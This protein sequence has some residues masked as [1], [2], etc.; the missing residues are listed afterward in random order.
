MNIANSTDPLNHCE[1]TAEST[2]GN[3]G[4]CDGGGACRFW[5]NT[6]VC[7]SQTCT[8]STKYMTD[9]C[10]GFGLCVDAGTANCCP[11]MCIGNTCRDSCTDNTH[12]CPG[13]FCISG[14]CISKKPNG[15][16]C[17]TGSECQSGFCVDGYCCN[18]GCAG[19]CQACNVANKLGTCTMLA[20]NT[21]P[22]NE[23]GSCKVCNGAG[24]CVNV[25]NGQDPV[26]E[27][28]DQVPCGQDGYCNGSAACRLW[29]SGTEC[30][31]QTCSGSTLYKQD[32]CDGL[33]QCVDS[34]SVS[35]APYKCSGNACA[36]NCATDDDC[37][38]GYYC[39]ASVC[40][41]KKGLGEACASNP[42]CL[43]GYC[44]DGYC[45]DNACT[46]TCR[47]CNITG[48]IGVC[49]F[50]TNNQDLGSECGMCQACNGAGACKFVPAGQDPKNQCN[51]AAPATCGDDG[52]CSGAGACRKYPVSTECASQSCV[53][54]TLSPTDY[55]NGNGSCVDSPT[56]SCCPYLCGTGACGTSCNSNAN[57]C[58]D[59][60]CNGSACV[61]K[62]PN[63]DPC[64]NAGQCQSGFCVDGY[65]CNTACTGTCSACNVPTKLGTCSPEAAGTD[66]QNECL[67]CYQCNGASACAA[68]PAGQDPFGDCNQTDPATCGQ[69][70]NCGGS[71]ACEMWPATTVCAA[72]TC[73]GNMLSA[74]DYCN[75]SGTC[76]DKG[77]SSCCPYTCGG[78]SC[79][80]GCSDNTHCCTGYWCNGGLCVTKKANGQTCTAS[81]ECASGFC[82]DGVCCD[83]ACNGACQACNITG[84]VGN[85][86]FHAYL[87]DPDNDC[88]A[89][90][91]CNGAGACVNAAVGTDPFNDCAQDSQSTC[92][93]DGTCSGSGACRKWGSN[94]ICNSQNCDGVT[95]MFSPTDYCSGT[96]VCLDSGSSSCCPFNCLGDSCRT[97]CL[98]DGN[99]CPT[100]LCK[101]NTQC[102]NCSSA[103]PCDK[104]QYC[105]K[106][107]TCDSIIEVHDPLFDNPNNGDAT[108]YGSTFGGNNDYDYGCCSNENGSFANDRVYHFDTKADYIGVEFTVKVWGNFDPVIYL[109][110]D[111]CGGSGVKIAYN[112]DY[113]GLGDGSGISMKLQPG[114]D[115]YLYVDG[116][117]TSRGEYT[118][119]FDFTSLCGNCVCDSGYGET[120]ATNPVEC[121]QSGDYCGNFINI[122]VS[123]RPQRFEFYD[124]LAGDHDDV[125]HYSNNAGQ[126]MSYAWASCS[127]CSW[128]HDDFDKVYRLEI[129]WDSTYVD[130]YY[131]R[132]GGWSPYN[133]PRLIVWRASSCNF[134]SV[135][136]E[137][138]ICAWGDSVQWGSWTGPQYFPP[139]IYWIIPDMYYEQSVSSAPYYLRITLWDAASG[140]MSDMR[141]KDTLRYVPG[142]PYEALGLKGASWTWTEEA[143]RLYG[144]TGS[145]MGLIAQEVEELYPVAV[146]RNAA[147]HLLIDYPV[148]DA[149]LAERTGR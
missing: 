114:Y 133:Y 28:S 98:T 56:T 97:A 36:T 69:S 11:Y 44:V 67:P 126:F 2:C 130:I 103:V 53:G 145:D 65:C 86:T 24:L 55:C 25:P 73:T 57:C 49:T 94:V 124:D 66:P 16:T 89:C 143:G 20:T 75:G 26:A 96:G 76:V 109:K 38:V 121:W 142:S 148:L 62:K 71:G 23:C 134:N 51:A 33:G 45:C 37:V 21:D 15:Q 125:S 84:F 77:S 58:S 48:N 147:G 32:K 17:A 102:Q 5:N 93:N 123:A 18:T 82:V 88:P 105:C 137:G 127:D 39:S 139:G 87:S 91:V 115:W 60:Y 13:F 19:T 113:P 83:K 111:V 78:N 31:A 122:P 100:A 70:G 61:T 1:Q 141:L 144:L 99:C 95:G 80:T 52:A 149:I 9:M 138:M 85:C 3:D 106:G 59:A 112:D 14:A 40:I 74:A 43:S 107:D 129:P 63:G 4:A 64:S 34:G 46:G 119:Q 35:C 8:G 110:R 132:N 108:Y 42:Q 30:A 6:T 54:S 131:G 29:A 47:A 146:R 92:G 116:M 68:I 90:V 101:S 72:Q 140:N 12:C 27:C 41:P 50:V 117:G 81:A 10:S 135:G 104:G 7:Q 128:C 22:D 79:R 136:V 120:Q 118:I